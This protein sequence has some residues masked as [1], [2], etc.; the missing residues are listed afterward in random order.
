MKIFLINKCEISHN[1]HKYILLLHVCNIF[2]KNI[3]NLKNDFLAASVCST[4]Q[5][6]TCNGGDA[7]ISTC[8]VNNGQVQCVCKP[9]YALNAD[10]NCEG[11]LLYFNSDF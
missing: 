1:N 6:A 3:L 2:N 7:T 5:A 8:S 9:G 4:E 10:N 11:M